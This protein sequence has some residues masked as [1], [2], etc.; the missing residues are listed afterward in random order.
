MSKNTQTNFEHQGVGFKAAIGLF[1]ANTANMRGR[2]A[3][4]AFLFASLF[5]VIVC[6]I[7]FGFSWWNPSNVILHTILMLTFTLPWLSLTIRR[8]H[9]FG[10]SG[11]VPYLVVCSFWSFL[12]LMISTATGATEFSALWMNSI[13]ESFSTGITGAHTQSATGDPILMSDAID[14]LALT[15]PTIYLGFMLSLLGMIVVFLIAALVPSKSRPNAHGAKIE[16]GL[17]AQ[18]MRRAATQNAD[19]RR[20]RLTNTI[21]LFFKNT[22][23]LKGRTARSGFLWASLFASLVSILTIVLWGIFG[24]NWILILVPALFIPWTTLAMR[25]AHDIGWNGFVA[26][27]P[28]GAWVGTLAFLAWAFTAL[29]ATQNPGANFTQSAVSKLAMTADHAV[30]YF[31][32]ANFGLFA[33]FLIGALVPG[34][35]GTNKYGPDIEAGRK[36]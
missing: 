28:V 25:R 27:P 22:F 14:A 12:N 9:D 20:V 4:N 19:H 17:A 35:R 2:S 34:Q 10:W 29:G 21:V 3:R 5:W 23:L 36:K 1:F 8:F 33:S 31:V 15:L 30:D 26:F 24:V 18:N 13:L 32:F 11:F 6:I 16:A 7:W